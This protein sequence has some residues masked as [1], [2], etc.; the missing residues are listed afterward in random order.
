MREG[1][2]GRYVGRIERALQRLQA[3]IAAGKPPGLGELA[4]EAAMSE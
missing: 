3:G 1:Q 2:S 4:R